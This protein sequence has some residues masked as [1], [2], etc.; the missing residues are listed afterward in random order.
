M[1]QTGYPWKQGKGIQIRIGKYVGQIGVCK[2]KKDIQEEFDGLLYAMQGRLLEEKP[3]D[4]G[5]W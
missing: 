5:N 4:I 2:A 1:R 3:R